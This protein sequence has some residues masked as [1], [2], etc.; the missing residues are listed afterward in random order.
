M[1]INA[2]GFSKS[3]KWD[4]AKCGAENKGHATECAKCGHEPTLGR[5]D[6]E[7]QRWADSHRRDD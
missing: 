6:V 3:T 7:N 4:C 1:D 2:E 5:R